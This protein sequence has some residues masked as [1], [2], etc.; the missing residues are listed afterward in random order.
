MEDPSSPELGPAGQ[1]QPG[2]PY[3]LNVERQ[4]KISQDIEHPAGNLEARV[5]RDI[6]DEVLSDVTGDD[7]RGLPLSC[8]VMVVA[9]G[10]PKPSERAANPMLSNG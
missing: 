8:G 3:V 5:Q 1:P 6:A 2:R 9:I 10:K 7:S 4:T